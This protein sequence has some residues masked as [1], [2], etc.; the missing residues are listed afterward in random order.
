METH[1]SERIEW[2]QPADLPGVDLLIGERSTRP[3]RVYHETYTVCTLVDVSGGDIEWTYRGKLYSA[4]AGTL[5]LMQPGEVHANTRPHRPCHFRVLFIAPRVVEQAGAELGIRLSRLNCKS[6]HA[7]DPALFRS[8]AQLHVTFGSPATG[9]ERESRFAACH[10]LLLEHWTE[11]GSSVCKQPARASLSQA[12][13][14]ICEHHSRSVALNELA[15]VS[16]LSRFHLVRAFAKEFGVPPH[17]YQIRVQVAKAR[18]LL[19]ARVPAA[20]VAAETGFA[21]QSHLARHFKQI[22]GVTPGRYV[23]GRAAG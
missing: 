5:P 8:F 10:Q 6:G 17:A 14:Y 13:D 21:D 20:E 22:Y 4:K 7:A 11:A 18:M 19:A 1:L 16:G 2:S 9:L 3:W 23:D 12:R 15:A